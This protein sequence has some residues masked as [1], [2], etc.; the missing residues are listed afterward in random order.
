MT[1]T[2]S[3]GANILMAGLVIGYGIGWWMNQSEPLTI[4]A[5]GDYD[6]IIRG[7]DPACWDEDDP[8]TTLYEGFGV[9][10]PVSE[11]EDP[12]TD[13]PQLVAVI[14]GDY[15]ELVAYDALAPGLQEGLQEAVLEER[16]RKFLPKIPLR[17]DDD[18]QDDPRYPN[19]SR[20][21]HCPVPLVDARSL[22]AA[23]MPPLRL[24]LWHPV[25][26]AGLRE[27]VPGSAGVVSQLASEVL[28]RSPEQLALARVILRSPDS[29]QYL[30]PC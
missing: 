25:A 3:I 7:S 1:R 27:D 23:L 26:D 4:H 16:R 6:F 11:E 29:P 17:Y 15:L 5:V 14:M 10:W 21:G 8:G 20:W 18:T 28:H 12:E 19:L 30:V 2:W 9:S 22:W 13:H 24:A